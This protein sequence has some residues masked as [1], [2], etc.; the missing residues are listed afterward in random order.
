MASKLAK[1]QGFSQVL[2]LDA[3]ERKYVE[4]VGSMN[5]AF[6]LND[7]IYTPP[8][9]G[10]ILEGI[11]RKSI[12]QLSKDLNIPLKEEALSIDTIVDE[13]QSGNLTEIFGMGTAASIAPV[14]QIKY[15]NHTHTIN[16]N[17]IGPITKKIYNELIGIQYGLIEDRHNWMYKIK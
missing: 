12:I 1:S 7:T 15:K 3:K 16:N 9:S 17:E 13:I 14:G 5:I 10:S 4:E 6:V 8:L 11:T 2:W